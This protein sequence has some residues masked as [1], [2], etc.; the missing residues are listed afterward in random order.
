MPIA[1]A[2][3]HAIKLF[4]PRLVNVTVKFAFPPGREQHAIL[5]IHGDMRQGKSVKHVF[6]EL[7]A[8]GR[9]TVEARALELD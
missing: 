7:A 2:I 6:F 4:E 3:R 1:D 8:S 9:G 5:A